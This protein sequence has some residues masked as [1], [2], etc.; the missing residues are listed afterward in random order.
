MT[1]PQ[2]CMDKRSIERQGREQQITS[3]VKVRVLAQQEA[4]EHLIS[5]MDT[6]SVPNQFNPNQPNPNQPG[7][8]PT[9]RWDD[10]LHRLARLRMA[11]ALYALE[12]TGEMVRISPGAWI[13][14]RR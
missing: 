10:S 9:Y 2:S 13:R 12:T 3:G 11:R 14:R 6:H 4:L 8:M 5:V 7:P 1:A